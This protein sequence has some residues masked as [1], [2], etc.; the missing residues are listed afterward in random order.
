MDERETTRDEIP[1]RDREPLFVPL[2]SETLGLEALEGPAGADRYSTILESQCGDADDSQPVEQYEGTLGGARAQ[3][4]NPFSHY[5]TN[6][7]QHSQ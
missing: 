3:A 1:H 4:A 2:P 5:L 6:R 7:T